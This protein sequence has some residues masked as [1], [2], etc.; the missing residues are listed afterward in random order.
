MMRPT[1]NEQHRHVAAIEG[2]GSSSTGTINK[3]D[4]KTVFDTFVCLHSIHFMKATLI[5]VRSANNER[6]RKV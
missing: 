6:A 1:R 4:V 3:K 5:A 2:I